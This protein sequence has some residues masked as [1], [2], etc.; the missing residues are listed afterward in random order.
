MEVRPPQAECLPDAEEPTT[1]AEH[2]TEEEQ[3][4]H[5]QEEEEVE[6]LGAC[7]TSAEC[8]ALQRGEM[9]RTQ[10]QLRGRITVFSISGCPHCRAAKAL[11]QECGVPLVDI[12]LDRYPERR[13]EMVERT[14][15]RTV[16]QIFFNAVHAGGNDRLQELA[17]AGEL[18]ALIDLVTREAPADAP[19]PPKAS[20]RG[21]L[22]VVVAGDIK[23]EP[24]AAALLV[25]QMRRAGLVHNRMWHLRKYRKVFVGKEAVDWLISPAS[26]LALATRAEAVELGNRLM[27]HH[28]LHHV[29]HDHPF[30]DDHLFY[31]F[32]QD[33]EVTPMT[34]NATHASSCLARPA[35]EVAEEVRRLIVALYDDFLSPDGK[36][37]DYAGIARS[38]A[39]RRYLRNAAELQR[40]DLAHLTREEKLAFFIN[41]Y[42]AMVIHA[43]VEVGPPGSLIQRHRFFNRVT[44]LIGGHFFSLNDIE[45]GILRGNRKP[46]GGLG[47]QFSRSDP[48][49]PLCL[50]EPEPRI[51]FALVCGAKSCPAIK[52]YRASDVD[53]ALTTATEAFFEVGG[54]NLQLNPPKRE[55]KL[56]RILDWYRIDF[57]RTDEELLRWVADFVSAETAKVL[58][59]WARDGNCKVSFLKYDWSVNKA[60]AGDAVG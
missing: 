33:E 32:I 28:Y 40:V 8:A 39:F 45:H 50:P 13:R 11:L 14:N 16:P 57:A 53:D 19:A 30:A 59:A 4:H 25:E 31:R 44:Y 27:A 29:T 6:V 10:R 36:E 9:E 21:D 60:A 18:N 12:D 47:R 41:V 54:G 23:C 43:Y 15:Q 38:E 51:H 20:T 17:A 37:V 46:P 24:D 49:L 55:V 26:G 52:T 2:R 3:L 5:H 1:G 58:R 34:L 42:N 7:T 56:S 22:G 35:A 48:R